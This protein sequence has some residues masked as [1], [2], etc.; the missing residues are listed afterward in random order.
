MELAPISLNREELNVLKN[1]DERFV[2]WVWGLLEEIPVDQRQLVGE[3]INEFLAEKENI[4]E[5][6]KQWWSQRDYSRFFYFPFAVSHTLELGYPPQDW[7]KHAAE[8]LIGK[9]EKDKRKIARSIYLLA[10]DYYY[11]TSCDSFLSHLV[12]AGR[13]E[14][15]LHEYREALN[16]EPNNID[17]RYALIG[18]LTPQGLGRGYAA[19]C[20]CLELLKIRPQKAT[21]FS[22][23]P[24]RRF[25]QIAYYLSG[26]LD[27][28]DP[29]DQLS[30]LVLAV[31][32][33]QAILKSNPS[34]P[35]IQKALQIL[36]ERYP[37]WQTV[38]MDNV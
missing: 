17:I 28:V 21:S 16:F 25:E 15:A 13:L 27:Y 8:Y 30:A 31:T 5:A 9:A 7:H 26:Y 1:R 12:E 35:I 36:L 20:E 23:D 22:N 38:R 4:L 29:E 3:E 2:D 18:L 37:L 33:F 11:D 10:E 32:T 14:W 34:N 19:F 24:L 6:R